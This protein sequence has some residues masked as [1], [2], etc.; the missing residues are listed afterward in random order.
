MDVR[1]E[2]TGKRNELF[3]GGD[4]FFRAL[5]IS[6]DR[7]RSFLIVPELWLRDTGFEGLQ[8]IAVWRGVKDS[9]EPY[10]CAA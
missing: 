7:L 10:S 3:V 2:V 5:A 9:S 8:A 4:L 6:Q 1:V